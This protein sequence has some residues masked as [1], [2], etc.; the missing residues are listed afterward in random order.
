MNADSKIIPDRFRPDLERAVSVLR[1]HGA[2]EIYLFGSIVEPDDIDIAV[3]GLRAESF[4]HAYGILLGELE[5][6][7]NEIDGVRPLFEKPASHE[8]DG[9][10]LR[11]AALTLRSFYNGVEAATSQCRCYG[12]SRRGCSDARLP[13]VVPN[14]QP[15]CR[16]GRSCLYEL[17][18]RHIEEG[19]KLLC[20]LQ[21]DAPVPML[22]V[23]DVLPCE[24]SQL[25]AELL[26]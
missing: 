18:Y 5:Q 25:S 23:G 8:P 13:L 12:A 14:A 10:E 2:Q 26:L 6:L 4:L 24:P 21:A 17:L 1:E 7:T 9:I 19:S 11:T 16:T 15:E 3:S 22:H 20:R